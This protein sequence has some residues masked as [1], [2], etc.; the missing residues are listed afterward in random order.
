MLR[1]ENHTGI[2]PLLFLLPHPLVCLR[3]ERRA[4]EANIVFCPER[5]SPC[6][7]T[8]L[9]AQLLTEGWKC[10]ATKKS[11]DVLKYM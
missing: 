3:S 9:T 1:Y 5:G 10:L 8:P 4:C 7:Q 2:S 11:I 6:P